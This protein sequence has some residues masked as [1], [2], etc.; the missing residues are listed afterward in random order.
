MKDENKKIILTGLNYEYFQ[1]ACNEINNSNFGNLKNL[2]TIFYFSFIRCYLYYFVKLQIE[3][4]E[5]GDLTPIHHYLFDISN[6]NLGQ[7]IILYIAKLFILLDKKE[8]FLK[9]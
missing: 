7:M 4:K 2:G 9:E 3:F 8:Y 1:R 6:S 5:L